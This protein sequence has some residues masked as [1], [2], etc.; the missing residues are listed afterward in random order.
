MSL[1]S[2]TSASAPAPAPTLTHSLPDA[3]FNLLSDPQVTDICLNG[4]REVFFDSGRGLQRLE[5]AAPLFPSEQAFRNFVLE[6]ISLSGKTWDAKLPF[7][8]TIFFRTHRAHI[9]FPPLAQFGIY[10][11]LRRLPARPLSQA[12]PQEL[13]LNA[14]ETARTRWI[15]SKPAFELLIQAMQNRETIIFAG[16][17]GSGKTTLLNDLLSFA[18]ENDRIIALEDTPEIHPTHPHFISLLS[19]ISNA[20][21]HGLVTLRDLLKQTLRMRPDRLLIGECRGDEVLDLLQALNTGHRGTLSTVHAN[22][23]RDALRR[24]E[25]MSLLAAKGTVPASLM[26]ELIVHGVQK[27]V[28]LERMNGERLIQSVVQIAGREGDMI[29]TRPLT[30]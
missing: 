3:L 4:F 26:K 19:R 14:Q 18:D 7:L 11:S 22:S 20:D 17:T 9:C 27:I 13:L 10:L 6:Q 1:V 28:F 25:L 2:E 21:G 12:D 16:S 8:D 15:N 24:I 23:A 5:T 29:C 30:T